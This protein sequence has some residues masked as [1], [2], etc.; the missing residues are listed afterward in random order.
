MH[1]PGLKYHSL[2][3]LHMLTLVAKGHVGVPL[4]DD[5][6]A[7]SYNNNQL[8]L[9]DFILKLLANSFPH[10]QSN[11]LQ[12]FVGGMFEKLSSEDAFKGHLRDFLVQL[13]EFCSTD[14]S[15]LMIEEKAAKEA[16]RAT[17]L[18][19]VPGMVGP[20]RPMTAQEEMVDAQSYPDVDNNPIE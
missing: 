1:K 15:D 2:I 14:N 7:A 16:E 13:K 20:H 12:N 11:Q 6:E 8:F 4:W 9:R 17:Q 10:L 3:L 5:N 18:A 19:C